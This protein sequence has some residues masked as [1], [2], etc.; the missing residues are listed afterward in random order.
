LTAIEDDPY[1]SSLVYDFPV[2][3]RNSEVAPSSSIS[4]NEVSFYGQHGSFCV[5]FID[6]VNSTLVTAG[7]TD[8]QISKYYSLFLNAMATIATNFGAKIIKN[9][10]DCLICY[11]PQTF[12]AS[13]L[14]PLSDSLECF[15][16][17]IDAWRPINSILKSEGL[18]PVNYRLSADYGEVEIAQSITLKGDDL[19]GSTMNLCAKIN[20]KSAENGLVIGNN[21]Y[22]VLSA[23]ESLKK[24]YR[25]EPSGSY[26]IHGKD[27][28]LV[29][30]VVHSK[31]RSILNP[32]KRTSVTVRSNEVDSKNPDTSKRVKPIGS[33]L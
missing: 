7:L 8:A 28:Y 32:F 29:Y 23:H 14:L 31:K 25:F 26:S 17:M 1:Y 9:A 18:P 2:I 19:F 30:S 20:S 21:L 10:G 33:E 24:D 6:I 13:K 5:C 16:T 3:N 15:M 4:F 27:N 12:D 11:F 22:K